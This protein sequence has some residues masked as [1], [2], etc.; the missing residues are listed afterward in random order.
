MNMK[1]KIEIGVA[2]AAVA[3]ALGGTLAFAANDGEEGGAPLATLE[4]QLTDSARSA[5]DDGSVTHGE[6]VTAFEQTVACMKQEGIPAVLQ[7]PEG[8]PSIGAE[9]NLTDEQVVAAEDCIDQHV[10]ALSAAY[11]LE[12]APQDGD[13]IVAWATLRDCYVANGGN[14]DDLPGNRFPP[15]VDDILLGPNAEQIGPCINEN[16]VQFGFAY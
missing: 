10:K 5:L 14:P 4:S 11:A 16:M 3:V 8:Q 7:N 1:R 15:A 9:G 12:N 13:R 6:L 2:V